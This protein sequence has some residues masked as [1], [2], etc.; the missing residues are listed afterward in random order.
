MD[1]WGNF[2]WLKV[3]QWS[4][5]YRRVSHS[6]LYWD[7]PELPGKHTQKRPGQSPDTRGTEQKD[8]Q[9][10]RGCNQ[11]PDSAP[12][13]G[14]KMT[15]RVPIKDIWNH[16]SYLSPPSLFLSEGPAAQ[17]FPATLSCDRGKLCSPRSNLVIEQG[18]GYCSQLMQ[19]QQLQ[20]HLVCQ[21]PQK[22]PHPTKTIPKFTLLMGA[23]E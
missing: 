18:W 14:W 11:S 10:R 8:S 13:P 9:G 19:K 1:M 17:L 4:I 7:R 15:V 20:S 16:S 2:G 12:S 22:E 6:R 5:S 21:F 23:P 3:R